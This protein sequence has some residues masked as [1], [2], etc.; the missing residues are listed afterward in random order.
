[1]IRAEK[2]IRVPI[3]DIYQIYPVSHSTSTIVAADFPRA[4]SFRRRGVETSKLVVIGIIEISRENAF[5]EET[6]EE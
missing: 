6:S 3:N 1:M 4:E 2:T 5:F